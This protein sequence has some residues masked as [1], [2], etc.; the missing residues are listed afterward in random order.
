MK[1]YY[2]AESGHG[3]DTSKGFAN[4]WTV[5]VFNG[6]SARDEFVRTR[7]NI[8]T[9]S[10]RRDEATKTAANWSLT[11]NRLVEPRP[12]TGEYWCIDTTLADLYDDIPGLVGTVRVCDGSDDC[13]RFYD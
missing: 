6:R 8:T 10:I 7:H 4:D 13:D 12:F 2:A 5:Y 1:K 3:S 9:K 11:Q